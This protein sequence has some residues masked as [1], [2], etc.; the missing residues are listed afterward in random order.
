MA[1]GDVVPGTG[2][3]IVDAIAQWREKAWRDGMALV[4]APD[5]ATYTAVAQR[6]EREAWETS[7]AIYLASRYPLQQATVVRDSYCAIHWN[8]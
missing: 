8:S 4:E 5:Q 1:A 2:T 7:L 3:L 6:I